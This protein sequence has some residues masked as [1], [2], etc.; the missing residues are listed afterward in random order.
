MKK[1]V[2]ILLSVICLMLVSFSVSMVMAGSENKVEYEDI[3]TI[4][5]YD[6]TVG[7]TSVTTPDITISS[8][9]DYFS[10][11]NKAQ[12][13]VIEIMEE[14]EVNFAR[15]TLSTENS[16]AAMS[17][18]A[19]DSERLPV[20]QYRIT[21]KY[22]LSSN[23]STTDKDFIFRF[24]S[25]T[26][27]DYS[28]VKDGDYSTVAGGWQIAT[29]AVTPV[30]NITGFWIFAYMGIDC[31]FDVQSI[32]V[33][34]AGIPSFA[35]KADFDASNPDDVTYVADH[36]GL[37]IEKV[38]I[39]NDDIEGFDII[40]PSYYVV[41]NDKTMTIKKEYLSTLTNGLKSIVS[42][43]NG[44]QY[45][46]IIYV[47]N[48]NVY[49]EVENLTNLHKVTFKNGETVIK[50]SY[51][52]IT[53]FVDDSEDGQALGWYNEEL[54]LYNQGVKIP[55]QNPATKEE[56]KEYVFTPV[57]LKLEMVS[58]ASIRLVAGGASGLEF[59][60]K[61]EV[62][63][64]NVA[65][66]IS[67]HTLIAPLDTITSD[68]IVE[69]YPNGSKGLVTDYKV[70]LEFSAIYGDYYK[71]SI[72]NIFTYNYAREFIG[73]G[74]V[75]VSYDDG[76]TANIYANY[77]ETNARSIYS[78]ALMAYK[79][80][81][82]VSDE[83]Y[84]TDTKDGYFS[85]FTTDELAIIKSYIDGV[86]NIT[87]D[88]NTVAVVNPYADITTGFNTYEVPYEV[89]VD[90][91][92]SIIISPKTDSGWTYYKV[93]DGKDKLYR[94]SVIINGERIVP[95]NSMYKITDS[96]VNETQNN[97]GIIIMMFGPGDGGDIFP[98]D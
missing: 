68:F 87:V 72:V 81:T 29:F 3:T 50:S 62:T 34:G 15:V 4:S 80:R 69:N 66:K 76:T 46:T 71:G 48:S 9:N 83:I 49:E 36:R 79:D 61:Y 60:T 32:K 7:T 73:R 20:Q 63:G 86:V 31:Y 91:N 78:V 11:L 5:F 24:R 51:D 21:L 92:G 1:I 94:C 77:D 40:D 65:E 52:Y 58:G 42:Y 23:F 12:S 22:R 47:Y 17:F 13:G 56:V 97:N 85:R 59:Y 44:R 25:G 37:G 53:P 67:L 35:E 74:F 88:N 33:E 38:E 82:T 64:A 41:N 8:T 16:A 57:Y 14:D 39:W 93:L 27:T 84:V 89:S 28:V 54:G 98:E 10:K 26:N 6:S 55:I 96:T 30:G 75:T 70:N 18:V 90:D 95:S 45:A 2:L 43:V 19:T